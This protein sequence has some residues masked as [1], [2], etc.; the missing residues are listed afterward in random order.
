MSIQLTFQKNVSILAKYN[1]LATEMNKAAAGI[2][3]AEGI[4]DGLKEFNIVGAIG[5]FSSFLGGLGAIFTILGGVFDSS[6]VQELDNLLKVVNRGFLKIEAR[7]EGLDVE[8][9]NVK[10]TVQ[11]EHFWT[12]LAPELKKLHTVKERI[13][14]VYRAEDR[15]ERKI[16]WQ[17]LDKEQFEKV[18]D[19]FLAIE[20]TF[21]GKFNGKTLCQTLIEFT[22]ADAARINVINRD[23]FV[24][25]LQGAMDIAMLGKKLKITGLGDKVEKKLGSIYKMMKLC[26]DKVTTKVWKTQWKLDADIWLDEVKPKVYNGKFVFIEYFRRSLLVNTKKCQRAFYLL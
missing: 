7:L 6:E 16:A 17:A 26:N 4:V 22:K 2:G 8:V 18:F 11:Q 10:R 23:L 15:I 20:G 12:K 24:R 5:K 9:A 25:L 3:I 21:N 13:M 1:T 19:A 14:N